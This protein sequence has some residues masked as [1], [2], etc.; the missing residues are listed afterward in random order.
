MEFTYGLSRIFAPATPTS[1]A[2]AQKIWFSFLPLRQQCLTPHTNTFG[3]C[4]WRANVPVGDYLEFS[5]MVQCSE[6]SA[7][8]APDNLLLFK[9]RRIPISSIVCRLFALNKCR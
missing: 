9:N 3:R 6:F 5:Q 1:S 8:V 7:A 4:F 2:P